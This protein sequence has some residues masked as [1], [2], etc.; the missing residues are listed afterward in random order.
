M[1]Q[2]TICSC[3]SFDLPKKGDLRMRMEPEFGIEILEKFN[4]SG[5]P[6]RTFI[7]G[8]HIFIQYK[9][10]RDNYRIIIV[11][12]KNFLIIAI[13]LFTETVY[14]MDHRLIEYIAF[15]WNYDIKKKSI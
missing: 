12:Q 15:I 4:L 13:S 2:L 14:V 7:A 10:D 9:D 8:Y 3:E 1:D 6:I 5:K 11:C